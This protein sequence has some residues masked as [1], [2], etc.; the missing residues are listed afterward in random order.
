MKKGNHNDSDYLVN[1]VATW[2]YVTLSY[3]ILR[4]ELM[5]TQNIDL[6]QCK[7]KLIQRPKSKMYGQVMY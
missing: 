5:Q 7:A 3:P 2:L 6:N 4:I 1:I